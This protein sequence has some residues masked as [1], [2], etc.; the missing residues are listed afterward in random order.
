MSTSWIRVAY[1]VVLGLVL[2]CVSVFGVALAQP[3][4]EP[5]EEPNLSFRR[6]TGE[7]EASQNQITASIDKYF[8]DSRDYRDDFVDYQRNAFLIAAGIAALVAVIGLLLPVSVN[9]L[10]W[11][12]MLGAGFTFAWGLWLTTR[13]VPNPAPISS[14]VFAL[15]G[16]G[17]PKQLE[18]ADYF[19]QF[20]VSFVAL[21]MLLFIGL[22][23][24]TEWG[25]PQRRPVV[26]GSTPA[27]SL[28]TPSPTT[29]VAAGWGPPPATPAA[30]PAATSSPPSST[31]APAP[32]ESPTIRTDPP[33]AT[34]EW[35]RPG[36]DP[37]VGEKP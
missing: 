31:P 22:W 1:G 14:S 13:D 17:S 12:L 15:L 33:A 30:S 7:D 21:I 34:P 24:L 10:R 29:P 20:A 2:L 18:F 37:P 32:G 3:G 19:L 25:A 6:L 16:A 23:R 11:G 27:A 26:A 35:Q 36:G 8:D 5:P 28:H 9:Y 4:P